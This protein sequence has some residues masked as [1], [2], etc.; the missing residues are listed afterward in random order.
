MNCLCAENTV[1]R[2]KKEPKGSI[3]LSKGKKNAHKN[4]SVGDE[5]QGYIRQG[6]YSG[7]IHFARFYAKPGICQGWIFLNYWS[8]LRTDK[9]PGPWLSFY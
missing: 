3:F 6:E 7:A 8:S 1:C 4:H 9:I 5:K 2:Q